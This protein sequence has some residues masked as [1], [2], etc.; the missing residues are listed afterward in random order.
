MN[1]KQDLKKICDLQNPKTL[2]KIQILEEAMG[3]CFKNKELL[4]NAM[5][6]SSYVNETNLAN[7]ESN[8]RLEFLGDS[9]LS[10]SISTY[11]YEHFHYQEGDCTKLRALV[12]CEESLARVA[13]RL[14]LGEYIFLGKGEEQTGGRERDCILADATEA[15]IAAIYLDSD[16]QSVFEFI[17]RNFEEII[18]ESN[19]GSLDRDYKSR[20]QEKLQETSTEVVKYDIFDECGP[21]H[22]K[23]YFAN[24][25]Y[26]DKVIGTGQGK[27]KKL[28]QKAAAEDAYKN[29]FG[30]EG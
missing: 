17:I 6:H 26:M 1:T 2:K 27:S 19:S 28:A 30:K 29:M 11:I 5:I 16:F 3:Y 10:L 12:V 22:N 24:A 21:A 4:R 25:I 20:L 9:V 18:K 14:G 13:N 15:L 23:V 7:I 8:E